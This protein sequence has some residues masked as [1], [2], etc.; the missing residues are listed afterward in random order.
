[1]V[2]AAELLEQFQWLTED[3]SRNLAPDTRARVADEVADVLVYLVRIA[4]KLGI[5]L[6]SAVDNKITKN[7]EK[8]PVDRARGNAKK[9]TDL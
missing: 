1:M 7:A 8:Y 2:E 6:L 5:D 3:Q 9:Y 4:D